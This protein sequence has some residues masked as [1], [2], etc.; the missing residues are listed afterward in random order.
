MCARYCIHTCSFS[1]RQQVFYNEIHYMWCISLCV[2]MKGWAGEKGRGEWE[3]R[4]RGRERERERER[5][6]EIVDEL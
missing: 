2:R 6:G 4:E 3:E 5:E 1:L